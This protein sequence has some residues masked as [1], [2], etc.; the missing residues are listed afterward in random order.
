MK[1]RRKEESMDRCT[2]RHD[3]TEILLETVLNTKQSNT[4]ICLYAFTK[5]SLVFSN[6][7]KEGREVWIGALATMI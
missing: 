5:Q 6:P 1:R 7:R 4:K 2:G 3:L